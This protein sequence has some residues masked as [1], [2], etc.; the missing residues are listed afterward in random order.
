M[1]API[2]V[3]LS[4]PIEVIDQKFAHLSVREPIGADLMAASGE[5]GVTFLMKVG[6]ACA[7]VPIEALEKMPA[8]DVLAVTKAVSDFL[9]GP[10]PGTASASTSSAPV[11]GGPPSNT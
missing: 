2:I 8:R 4:R 1:L 6:A 5:T 9:E 7:N 10:P 11:G 3:K